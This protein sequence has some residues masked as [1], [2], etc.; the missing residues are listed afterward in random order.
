[1]RKCSL[2]AVRSAFTL[3]EL[4]VVIAI[5]GILVG[6]LLPAVQAAREA[7]RRMSCQNNMKQLG[8]AALNFESAYRRLTPGNDTRFNGPHFRLLPFMEQDAIYQSYD[9]GQFS[10]GASSWMASPVA[11]NI[12]NPSNPSYS[13]TPPLPNGRFAIGQ[14]NLPTFLCP[15]ALSPST[16]QLMIQFT[17]VGIPG[18]H[19]R[20]G[21]A[22]SN[23][24][25]FDYYIYNKNSSPVQLAETSR[26][27]YLFNRGWVTQ[28]ITGT[29]NRGPGFEGPFRYSPAI[30]D[31]A[32]GLARFVNPPSQG[33][34]IGS[35]KDGLSN[36]IF[37][38]ES[39]GG[40]FDGPANGV[41]SWG[42]GWM[43]MHWGHAPFYSN[44]G[45]CPDTSNGN[46]EVLPIGLGLGWGLP[47][48]LHAGKVINTVNGDGSV[49]SMATNM[50]FG[51]FVALCGG[52]DGEIV[53][54]DQ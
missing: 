31:G 35:V 11:Y 49:R 2:G 9:N 7:A 22:S 37:A 17:S 46:C 38:M 30:V 51:V 52:K 6:L 8:L 27:N 15:S 20:A 28:H 50:T 33:D 40:Y 10:P 26:T 44:F 48:S 34:K 42:S 53:T 43:G 19:F 16:E 41:A 23:N 4:L 25:S 5:I 36:T 1:M 32:S 21:F 12:P 54:I 29:D 3:V 45:F 14:P 24:P 47:G 13:G 39:A 18:T